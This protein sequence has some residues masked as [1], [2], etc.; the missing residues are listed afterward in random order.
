MAQTAYGFLSW[1]GEGFYPGTEHYWWSTPANYGDVVTITPH[2][3]SRPGREI[4]VKDVRT[5]VD[6][7]GGRTMLFTVRNT[8]AIDIPGYGLGFSFVSS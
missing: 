1:V 4:E 3:V 7:S 8:G 6:P 5:H 2:A